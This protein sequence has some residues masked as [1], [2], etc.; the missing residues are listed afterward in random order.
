[1]SYYRIILERAGD[2]KTVEG[3]INQKEVRH[4]LKSLGFVWNQ[5]W[6]MWEQHY[7]AVDPFDDYQMD[8]AWTKA[9]VVKIN[10]EVT[11]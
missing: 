3:F 1:M 2:A 10:S 9:T 8:T 6:E 11:V 7:M 5:Q 4:Y